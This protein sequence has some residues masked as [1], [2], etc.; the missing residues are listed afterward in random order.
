MIKD[1]IQFIIKLLNYSCLLLYKMYYK[2]N[3]CMTSGKD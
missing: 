3:I 1:I 2:Y